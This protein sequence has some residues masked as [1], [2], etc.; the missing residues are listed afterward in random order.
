MMYCF[1]C[2]TQNSDNAFKCVQCN[3]VLQQI[4][5]PTVIV[6]KN[7]AALVVLVIAGVLFGLIA[8]AGILAA[9]AIPAYMDFSRKAK[10]VEAV[11]VVKEIRTALEV[12]ASS[13]N[14]LEPGGTGVNALDFTT[15]QDKLEITISR[16]FISNASVVCNPDEIC[17]IT[18]TIKDIGASF[19]GQNL[20]LSTA[21]PAPDLSQW[22]WGRSTIPVRYVPK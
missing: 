5:T 2:G 12:K 19:D 13:S 7:S 15:I 6:K 14:L 1:K 18:A 3:T 16:N 21:N 20:V 9:I 11:Q 8:I 17:T 4:T 10:L 22:H